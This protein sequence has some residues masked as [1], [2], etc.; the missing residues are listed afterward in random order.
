MAILQ[1]LKSLKAAQWFLYPVDPE[2]DNVPDYLDV[3]QHPMDLQ[4]VEKKLLQGAY[5]HPFLWQQDVRQ[6]FFNA[7]SYHVVSTEV[8]RDAT[9]LA[10]EFERLHALWRD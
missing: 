8:W 6:V 9:A 3:V 10:L 7:F 4:T 5:P 1:H 2:A